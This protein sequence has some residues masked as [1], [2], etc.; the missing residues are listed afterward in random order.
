MRFAFAL[1]LHLK[2]AHQVPLPAA[3]FCCK[4]LPAAHLPKQQPP[5]ASLPLSSLTAPRSTSI[6]NCMKT[7]AKAN[8]SHTKFA[9]T[10][11][12]FTFAPIY[13]QMQP[14]SQQRQQL[15]RNVRLEQVDNEMRYKESGCKAVKYVYRVLLSCQYT[16]GRACKCTRLADNDNDNSIVDM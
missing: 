12:L 13:H 8:W 16:P 1:A 9:F 4:G 14:S 15:Q 2:A 3:A 5:V 10:F 6:A 7:W 11:W